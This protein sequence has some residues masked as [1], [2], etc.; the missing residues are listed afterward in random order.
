LQPFAVALT[1]GTRLGPYEVIAQI[2][3]GGMGEVYRARDTKL[4]RE[5]A[6]KILPEFFAGDPERIARFEREA[7]TLAALNH[8]HIAAIY[9]FEESNGLRALV[10]ELVEGDTLANLIAR[11]P[12]PPDEALPVARQIAE[13][14][15]AAHEQGIIHRDLKPANIKVRRDGTVKVL[16][17]GLAKL[18]RS[19]ISRADATISPTIT[20]PALETGA[21]MLL[22]TAAYMS[23]EQ[24]KGREANARSDVWA[25]GCVLYEMLTGQRAFVGDDVAETL[26]RVI[27]DEP[28]WNALPKTTAPAIHRLLRRCLQKDVG[29]RL[30]HIGVARLELDEALSPLVEPAPAHP[31]SRRERAAWTVAAM[32]AVTT[33]AASVWAIL[34]RASMEQPVYRMSVLPPENAQTTT[35]AAQA[36]LALSPDAKRLAFVAVTSNRQMMLWVRNLDDLATR[37]LPGTEGATSPSWS[38]DGQYLAFIAAG[39]LK[40]MDIGGG[41]AVTLT[42]AEVQ[43]YGTWNQFGEIV[44]A[45][46]ARTGLLRIPASGGTAAP[47][48]VL[49]D[50]ETAHTDPFFLP[51]GRHFL[52]TVRHGGG[53]EAPLN[54]YVGST[55][56]E[57]QHIHLLDGVANAMYSDG[58]LLFVRDTTLMA[59][60]FDVSRLTLTGQ[61]RPVATN[62]ALGGNTQRH[63]AFSVSAD[64]VIAYQNAPAGAVSQLTWFD[65]SGT[66]RETLGDA[67]DYFEVELSP[68]DSRAAVSIRDPARG[69]YDVW[70]V[71]V[72]RGILQRLTSDPGIEQYPL[73]SPDGSRIAFS[74][75]RD[76]RYGIFERSASGMG[77]E[78]ALLTDDVP[79]PLGDW[80]QDGHLL[81][82]GVGGSNRSSDLWAMSLGDEQKPKILD[83]TPFTEGGARLSPN[84]R[85]LAYTSNESGNV[86]VYVARFPNLDAKWRVSRAGGRV[87][88]WRRDGR[89]IFFEAPGGKIM[90][91]AVTASGQT[92]DV[93]SIVELF[94][95]DIAEGLGRSFDVT[96]DGQRFLVNVATRPAGAPP[97]TVLLNWSALVR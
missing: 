5:V 24:A 22:G 25:F 84:G 37:A 42:P 45:A 43:G 46:E 35:V 6:I 81:F 26:A 79:R 48:T 59:Q 53:P 12:I 82:G 44:F 10:M 60:P 64:G 71:D 33:I 70:V 49:R 31:A 69:T 29:H 23:P 56:A 3:A 7:K 72:H 14:L 74:T 94:Q 19:M 18:G 97:I 90:A 83:A 57:E 2:G 4:G 93:G 87:P 27:R 40:K 17:F 88:R 52:Y 65:R 16:D 95:A 11:G 47:V 20:G 80:S 30:P 66:R 38:P 34:P 36:R 50:G 89:E 85:W 32:L 91:A 39:S 67:A 55:D 68:D 61:A 1:A 76:G 8:S 54:V 9:G 13:A 15:E 73:W 51:D 92:V 21:G 41:S 96:A 78:K 58:H 63:G 28:Q 77:A 86:E 75:L 62:V